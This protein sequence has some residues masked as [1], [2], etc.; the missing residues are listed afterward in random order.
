MY[1]YQVHID[2]DIQSKLGSPFNCE[3]ECL[4]KGATERPRHCLAVEVDGLR[5]ERCSA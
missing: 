5:D 2:I 3:V 4:A 1:I